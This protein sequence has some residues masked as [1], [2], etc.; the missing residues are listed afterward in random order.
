LHSSVSASTPPTNTT[1]CAVATAGA[2]AT[3][4]TSS[5]KTWSAG[6]LFVDGDHAF[7]LAH[8]PSARPRDGVVVAR[9][10]GDDRDRLLYDALDRPPTFLYR[11]DIAETG[12]A[13]AAVVPWAPPEHGPTLRFE[14]EAEW[15][16]LSQRGGFAAPAWT[17][18]CAT[19]TRAL[20]L[21]PSG[22]AP[23]RATIEVPVPKAGQWSVGLRVV[24]GARVPFTSRGA[25]RQTLGSG[26][27]RMRGALWS[28][29]ELAGRPTCQDLAPQRV[30]LAP[31]HAILELEA[32]G[33]P[34]AIDHVTLAEVH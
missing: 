34:I 20:V 17:D 32:S 6:L 3:S 8:N 31:P 15:P 33:G 27:V 28:W 16:V 14:A 2:R 13:T 11:F 12:V 9:L 29:T 30:E 22:D 24:H 19:G 23:A 1:N 7:G 5:R 26:N 10:R 21:T 4:P 25:A 18:A